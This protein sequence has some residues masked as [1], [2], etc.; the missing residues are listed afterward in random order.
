MLLQDHDWKLQ[1]AVEAFFAGTDKEQD[2]RSGDDKS[3][4]SGL[5]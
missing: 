1:P 3:E 5:H 2:Q 4:V